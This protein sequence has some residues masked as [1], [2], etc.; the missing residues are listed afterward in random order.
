MRKVC[1]GMSWHEKVWRRYEKVGEGMR[2]YEKVWVGMRR[3]E[4][5]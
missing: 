3:Y 2:K 1:E 5:V 4:K